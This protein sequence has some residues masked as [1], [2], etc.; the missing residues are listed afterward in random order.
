M[1]KPVVYIDGQSGT[2]GLQIN[3]RLS[4]RT[5]IELVHIPEELHRDPEARKRYMNEADLVFFCLPDAAAVE[6]AG[7]IEN[8]GTRVIDAS[9][10]HRTA[11]GWDYGIPELAP[12]FRENIRK[13]H[14]VANPGCHASGFVVPVYALVAS[15]VIPK[16]TPLTVF[17]LT[18]YSGGGK[19]MIAEYEAE[20]RAP[21]YDAPRIYGLTLHHKHLPEM[22]KIVGL[23]VPP[24][25]VP[26]VDDY[27]KG[28][29]VTT[30]IPNA[31]LPKKPSAED[32]HAAL[33]EYYRGEKLV[34]VHPFGYDG[35]IAANTLAGSDR[36]EIIVNGH[37]DQTIV[38]AL[39]DNLGK[40]ASGAAVQNMNLMLGFDETEGLVI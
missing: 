9:T 16:D 14:R 27:Y 5:D 28:M 7:M 21:M 34:T 23:S 3:E 2:T 12:A 36:M 18:G 6:A 8:P 13:S 38:T 20:G 32:I 10:A 4:K 24:V 22:Q 19:K 40:G 31:I 17:S 15:G 35:M 39:F 33:S 1:A 37:E 11:E 25:F 29:A 30:M 26:V